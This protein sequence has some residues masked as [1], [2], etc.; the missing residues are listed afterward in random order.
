MFQLLCAVIGMVSAFVFWPS[1]GAVPEIYFIKEYGSQVVML[2][3]P[4]N[5]FSGG[6]GFEV[7]SPNSGRVYTITNGHVCAIAVNGLVAAHVPGTER[8]I[9]IRVLEVSD[10]TDLCLLEG[11]P[12]ASGLTLAQSFKEGDAITSIGHPYL[13]PLQA[14]Q[15][16]IISIEDIQ[17]LEAEKMVDECTGPSRQVVEGICIRTVRAITTNMRIFPGNSG[18]PTFNDDGDVVGVVFAGDTNTQH[19]DLIPLQEVRDF[20][21]VY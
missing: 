4:D 8:T 11:L 16:Y 5:Y 19:G 13:R 12:S 7:R 14:A 2:T 18:S 17:I 1:A 9:N 3:P 6:T 20:L 21:S 15:G 10:T